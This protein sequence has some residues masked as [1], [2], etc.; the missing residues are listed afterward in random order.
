MLLKSILRRSPQNAHANFLLG[1]HLFW[2]EK[3]NGKA[4]KFLETAV[5]ERPNFLRAV[6]CLGALYQ[7]MG[8]Q[9]LAAR[10]FR[11]CKDLE[12]DPSMKKYFSELAA[13]P[14]KP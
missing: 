4:I 14:A 1:S 9:P 6:A 2:V 8:N 7:T 11:K 13:K 12:S 5:R 3:Q 10:S